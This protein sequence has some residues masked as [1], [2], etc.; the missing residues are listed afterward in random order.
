MPTSENKD[1]YQALFN[2]VKSSFALGLSKEEGIKKL[3]DCGAEPD[4]A[5]GIVNVVLLHK[6]GYFSPF[7]KI[8]KALINLFSPR[9]EEDQNVFEELSEFLI[10]AE[11]YNSIQAINNDIEGNVEVLKE[12]EDSAEYRDTLY[13]NSSPYEQKVIILMDAY[14]SDFSECLQQ[15]ILN[16]LGREEIAKN[17]D[18]RAKWLHQEVKN[19]TTESEGLKSIENIENKSSDTEH[20]EYTSLLNSV[21]ALR[22]SIRKIKE[23]ETQGLEAHLENLQNQRQAYDEISTKIDLKKAV[24]LIVNTLKEERMSYSNFPEDFGSEGEKVY[25]IDNLYYISG[26]QEESKNG[27]ITTTDKFRFKDRIYILSIEHG[28]RDTWFDF[29][30]GS[31][32]CNSYYLGELKLK[33]FENGSYSEVFSM[34]LKIE[35]SIEPL[36]W[37]SM[38]V[39]LIT[40]GDWL[41][42][43]IELHELLKIDEEQSDL[44]FRAALIEGF[45]LKCDQNT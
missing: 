12:F 39:E 35:D 13:W 41:P 27:N 10:A 18:G 26:N 5:K 32:Q 2:A 45:K 22:H 24:I 33:H 3:Q 6:N 20:D 14:F 1:P 8:K 11:Y 29:D 42:E 34:G 38:S 36:S 37:E 9:K 28:E 31:E 16:L 19:M 7:T 43:I 15:K 30:L 40:V 44:K 21:D 17:I 25:Q 4:T 23:K